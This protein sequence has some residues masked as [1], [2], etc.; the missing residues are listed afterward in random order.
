MV[1]G[2]GRLILPGRYAR[3]RLLQPGYPGG[4]SVAGLKSISS[5]WTFLPEEIN[6]NTRCLP[7]GFS[8]DPDFGYRGQLQLF[9]P[10]LAGISR[11]LPGRRGSRRVAGWRSSRRPGSTAEAYLGAIKRR[12]NFGMVYRLLR[13]DGQ[14][15]WVRDEGRP[16][17]GRNG[18]Y[19][20]YRSLHRHHR[21]P[22][23]NLE[24]SQHRQHLEEL[25]LKRTAELEEANRRLQA[26]DRRHQALYA[27]SR[28]A[29][30]LDEPAL[31]GLCLSEAARLL[32]SNLAWL[33]AYDDQGRNH[34]HR[35]L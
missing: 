1:A 33:I 24:P 27:I 32:D 30:G 18:E 31:I 14:Y 9:Q 7:I 34:R 15:R 2:E 35:R 6:F 13:Q 19:Q 16:R 12:E 11:T 29:E 26:S 28:Q 22:E 20:G 5:T 8:T 4:A 25:V 21:K 10:P 3:H 17:Y 23:T